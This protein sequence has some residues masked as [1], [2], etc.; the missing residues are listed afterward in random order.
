LKQTGTI[1]KNARYPYSLGLYRNLKFVFGEKWYFWWL[2]AGA[3]GDGYNFDVIGNRY[4]WP[5]YTLSKSI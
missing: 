5:V 3:S 2:P 1:P 4:S